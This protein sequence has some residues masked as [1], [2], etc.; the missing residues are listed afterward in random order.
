MTA[1]PYDELPE[2][3]ADQLLAKLSTDD[4]FRALFSSD[5]RAALA[6]LGFGPASDADVQRGIWESLTVNQLADKQAIAGALASF[7]ADVLSARAAADP[8]SLDQARG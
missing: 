7:R 3:V 1:K 5:P 4:D 2:S 6:Q 8:I